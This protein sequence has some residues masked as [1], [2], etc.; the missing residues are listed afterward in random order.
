M[1]VLRDTVTLSQLSHGDHR[2]RSTRRERTVGHP[3]TKEGPYTR[4]GVTPVTEVKRFSTL[5]RP[6]G[7]LWDSTK[8]LPARCPHRPLGR[9]RPS[10]GR[11]A[12]AVRRLHRVTVAG[13]VPAGAEDGGRQ[14]ARAGRPAGAEGGKS[15]SIE[16]DVSHGTT[17]AAPLAA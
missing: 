6:G 12:R 7:G 13:D 15:C 9:P 10:A 3:R 11:R 17:V 14:G 1:K 5:L 2:R 8:S 4:E 16:G